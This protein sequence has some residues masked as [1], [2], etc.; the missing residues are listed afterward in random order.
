MPRGRPKK[1]TLDIRNKII[2]ELEKHPNFKAPS[3]RKHLSRMYREKLRKEG[4]SDTVIQASVDHYDKEILP[5]ESSIQKFIAEIKPELEEL[6]KP[7]SVSALAYDD[8]DIES[9]ALP[10]VMKAWA[11]ALEQDNPLTIRQVKW[12]AR[13][14]CL[15][16]ETDYDVYVILEIA[17]DYASREKAMKPGAYPDNPQDQ[18]MY[19]LWFNDAILYLLTRKDDRELP[20]F[21]KKEIWSSFVSPESMAGELYPFAGYLLSKIRLITVDEDSNQP[22]GQMNKGGTK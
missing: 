12:I 19:W 20:K 9:E 18:D 22:E 5:G 11:T 7:W 10:V 2:R 16:G 15:W 8:Y 14:Y 6:D 3:M 1:L 4:I 21:L 13:L 17:R